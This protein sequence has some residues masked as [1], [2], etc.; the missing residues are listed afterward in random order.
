MHIYFNRQTLHTDLLDVYQYWLYNTHQMSN[1]KK[2][3][4]EEIEGKTHKKS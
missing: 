1:I 4:T 3:T 2:S